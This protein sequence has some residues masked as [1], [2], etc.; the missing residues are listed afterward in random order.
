MI[1]LAGLALGVVLGAIPVSWVVH[2]AV[3]GGDLREVG[4]GNPGATNAWRSGGPVAGGLSLV[5]DLAKGAAAVALARALA[6]ES[7]AAAAAFG[8][9]LGHAFSPWL[10]LRGGKG[11]AAAMGAFLVAA[12]LAAL[13][14]LA[15]FGAA[16]VATRWVSA[17]SIVGALCLPIAAAAT[18]GRPD[19]V[20]A[21]AATAVLIVWRHRPNFARMR[22]GTEPRIGA[23]GSRRR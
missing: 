23:G 11:V 1:A 16:L 10:R 6:G 14:G 15:T 18:G 12:P 19:L 5:G 8:A 22:R 3:S 2:R 4:S 17:G 7:A 9:P 20:A 21:A 13:A